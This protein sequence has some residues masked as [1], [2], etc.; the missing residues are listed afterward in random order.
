MRIL[1]RQSCI[2]GAVLFAVGCGADVS[3]P[4]DLRGGEGGSEAG[5]GSAKGGSTKNAGGTNNKGG[6]PSTA[7]STGTGG[8]V[9]ATTGAG[10]SS[11][12][13][14][15][16]GSGGRTKAKGGSGGDE[17]GGRDGEGGSSVSAKGGALAGGNTGKGGSSSGTGGASGSGGKSVGSGGKTSEAGGAQNRGGSPG[18]GGTPAAG[19]VQNR[20]GSPGVGGAG[21]GGEKPGTGGSTPATSTCTE[22]QKTL[23]GNA[24]GTYCGLS[25]EYWSDGGSAS[26]IMK[27]GGFS[28]NFSVPNNNFLGRM[29]VRPGTGNETFTYQAQ[30]APKG[31]SYLAIYGWTRNPLVEYYIV[32]SYGTYNPSSAASKKGSATCN[33]GSYTLASNSRTGPSIEGNT[34]F[35]QY[36]SV[37]D[38]K[39]TSGDISIKCHFD[40]WKAAGM[41]MGSMYEVTMV[42]EGYHS[43]ETA[44][45]KLSVK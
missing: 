6:N 8:K 18:A 15:S 39:R 11:E 45:V 33:G 25:Y 35:Q 32:E 22:A 2:L 27:P 29:G 37:R 41:N 31:N 42:V 38:S 10:G 28:V 43:S 21:T 9:G 44:D 4:P 7:Q 26:M 3:D 20:G 19:G 17:S 1:S 36:W 16:D 34:T 12:K 5:G 23:N 30:Y 14:G 13:G 24:T 40:A